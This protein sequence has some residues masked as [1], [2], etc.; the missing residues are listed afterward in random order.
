MRA[1]RVAYELTYG[2]IPAGLNV[3]HSCDNPPCVRP[4][5]LRVGT[6]RDNAQDAIKRHRRFSPFKGQIQ[7][8]EMNRNTRLTS[9]DV[10]DIR[11]RYAAGEYQHSIAERYGLTRSNVSHIV[12]RKSWQ[13]VA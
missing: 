8:G 5:H 6:Q 11:R 12:R 9:E 4:D 3:L 1:H 10:R 13:S 2:P 7:A